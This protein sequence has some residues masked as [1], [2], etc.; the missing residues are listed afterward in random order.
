MK[1]VLIGLCILVILAAVIIG[2]SYFMPP[3]LEKVADNFLA[4]VI[5][6]DLE[7]AET[8]LSQEFIETN[9]IEEFLTSSTLSECESANW[10]FQTYKKDRGLLE[11]EMTTVDGREIDIDVCFIKEN[12]D[13]KID[14]I[15]V[16]SWGYSKAD[17]TEEGEIVSR[18]YLSDERVIE[19]IDN[20]MHDFAEAVVTE[21]F[22]GFYNNISKKWQAETS[23]DSLMATFKKFSESNID[24]TA[25]KNVKPV[26][27]EK[28]PLSI[29]E[30]FILEGNYPAQP[31]FEYVTYFTL[32]Y[33]YEFP[34]WKLASLRVRV[35]TPE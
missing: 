23:P 24:F 3:N 21:D 28:P 20:T 33:T 2:I 9:P 27:N 7:T 31:S 19:F 26:I 18:F 16:D 10:R 15:K 4:A 14:Y 12:G 6:D 25:L 11:G 29:K 22:T 35:N 32:K 13:L 5:Q 34:K 1:R 30:L 17:T 8:Y